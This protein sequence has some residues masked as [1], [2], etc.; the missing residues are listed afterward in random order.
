MRVVFESRKAPSITE[1]FMVEFCFSTPRIIMHTHHHAHVLRFDH[2]RDAGGVGHLLDR[3]GDFPGEIF[4]DLQAPGEHVDNPGDLRQPQHLA[5]WN[6][7][8]MG[9]ADEGQQMMFAQRVQLDVLDDHHLVVIRGEQCTVDHAF[10]TF[11]VA[12][13]QV[14]HGL[15]CPFRGVQQTLAIRVFAKTLEDLAV[16]LG[17]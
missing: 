14:L 10:D 2:H 9:L 5:G 3:L 12:V 13:T 7:G 15:G 6:V 8:D 16:M 11:G 17:Q 1:V 4:L